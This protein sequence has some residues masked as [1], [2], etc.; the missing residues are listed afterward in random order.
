MTAQTSAAA[1]DSAHHL[2]FISDT[3]LAQLDSHL[4]NSCQILYQLSEVHSAVS[5]EI[6]NYLAVVKGVLHIYKLHHKA[7]LIHLFLAELHGS[8]LLFHVLYML[9]MVFLVGNSYNLLKRAYDILLRYLGF[10]H[11]HGTELQTSGGFNDYAV[12]DL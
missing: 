2:G 10:L 11:G 4:E 3:D 6:E 5:C 7:V 8:F 12:S 1:S 9:T